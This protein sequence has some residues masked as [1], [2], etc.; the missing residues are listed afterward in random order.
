MATDVPQD[1]PAQRSAPQDVDA[2]PPAERSNDTPQD[3]HTLRTPAERST[4][5][6]L[7]TLQDVD[8]ATA[9]PTQA[10]ETPVSTKQPPKR[11][12]RLVFSPEDQILPKKPKKEDELQKSC[13]ECLVS[14]K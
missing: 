7:C 10:T 8:Q 13:N 14:G 11:K 5:M 9:G 1:P 3:G 6:S 2:T 12:T 4:N